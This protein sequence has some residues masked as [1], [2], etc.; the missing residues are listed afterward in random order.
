MDMFFSE[1]VGT[2]L[3]WEI[4]FVRI[5]LSFL[6]GCIMGLERKFRMRFV[7]IRTLVLI[8]VSSCVIMLLSIYLSRVLFAGSGDPARLAA[9][10]VSGIGF[11]G[12]GAI[13]RE[14]FN[15]KG[16]TSAA[17]IWTGAAL[18]L[19]IGAGFLFPAFVAL[20]F[21]LV[22][23]ILIEFLEEHFFPAEELKVLYLTCTENQPSLK[24][25]KPL[26]A[27]YGVIVTNLNNAS[28]VDNVLKVSYEA[29][30]PKSVDFEKLAQDLRQRFK[31][32]AVE[33]R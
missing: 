25:L 8:C 4:C 11:L 6:A 7:G 28:L 13:L 10:V 21:S 3:S 30:I 14:G 22:A 23:L 24:D 18:G 33:L 2:A 12:G 1:L 19:S 15:V 9:Q 31:V 16:L 5:F 17:I 29:R 20:I 26:A 27:K 32:T